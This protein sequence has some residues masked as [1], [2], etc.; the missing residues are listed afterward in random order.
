M[1]TPSVYCRMDFAEVESTQGESML[2]HGWKLKYKLK[3]KKKGKR[4]SKGYRIRKFSLTE[5]GYVNYDQ[6]LRSNDWKIIRADVLKNHPGCMLCSA[7]ASQVH[8][9]DYD[10]QTLL[11]LEK[12]LLAPLC[13]KCHHIIEFNKNEKR[14]LANANK[15]LRVMAKRTSSGKVLLKQ[16][17][18]MA[19]ERKQKGMRIGPGVDHAKRQRRRKSSQ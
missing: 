2:I 3:P 1:S 16:L 7:L 11:G 6:Y 12:R 5:L 14:T 17:E 15:M 18:V 19:E 9:M 4:T 8:H 13:D 10:A